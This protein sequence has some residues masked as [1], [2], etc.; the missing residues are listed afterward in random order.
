MHVVSVRRCRYVRTR[1]YTSLR[2]EKMIKKHML[3]W[4]LAISAMGLLDTAAFAGGCPGNCN[5]HGVC[6][7]GVCTCNVGYTGA[8]C[9]FCAPNYYNYPSCTFCESTTTCSGN[10]TCSAFGFCNC[11]AGWVGTNCEIP[12]CSGGCGNGVCSSPGV[13]D[14]FPGWTGPMCDQ[15]APV[16]TVSEWGLAVL[17]LTGLIAGTI[18]FDRRNRFLSA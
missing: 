6:N 14:C 9:G 16:P 2:G 11:N 5:G 4:L 13:C 10:G 17:T 18:L 12:F 7:S 8:D 1:G 3:V 15:P